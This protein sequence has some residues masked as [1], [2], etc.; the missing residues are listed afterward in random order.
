METAEG[1]L[2]EE[3][4]KIIMVGVAAD[5]DATTRAS[6]GA[7]GGTIGTGAGVLAGLFFMAGVYALNKKT[8]RKRIEREHPERKNRALHFH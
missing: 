7:A 3:I 4:S 1:I 6:Y 8:I 2:Y 5:R